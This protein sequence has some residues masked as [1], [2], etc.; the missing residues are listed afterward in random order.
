MLSYDRE[1]HSIGEML[2]SRSFN[3]EDSC[4][5]KDDLNNWLFLKIGDKR[6]SYVYKI[7]DP[8]SARYDEPFAVNMA[9]TAI[10][11]VIN[12]VQIGVTYEVLR[13]EELIGSVHL[14][15]LNNPGV[16]LN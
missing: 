8:Q 2:I 3:L 7:I 6:F 10:S 11:L 9:F 14:S 13:G 16:K 4:S 5:P 12:I 1:Y 15:T